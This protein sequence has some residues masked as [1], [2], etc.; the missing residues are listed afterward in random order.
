MTPAGA[1]LHR[2]IQKTIPDG[3]P[4]R[5]HFLADTEPHAALADF[6][7]RVAQV[8]ARHSSIKTTQN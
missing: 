6:R 1:A 2:L 5:D 7:A 3:T 4:I 8:S